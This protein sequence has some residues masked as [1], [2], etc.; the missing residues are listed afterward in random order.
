MQFH[1]LVPQ[2]LNKEVTIQLPLQGMPGKGYGHEK[3]TQEPV[4]KHD[5]SIY[6]FEYF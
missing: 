2:L 3:L 1:G 4:S 5:N 6:C